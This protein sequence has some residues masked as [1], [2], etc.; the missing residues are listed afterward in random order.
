MIEYKS[1]WQSSWIRDRKCT[2]LLT[3]QETCHQNCVVFCTPKNVFCS[4]HWQRQLDKICHDL[5]FSLG[6][7]TLNKMGSN[8]F[9]QKSHSFMPLSF[10]EIFLQFWKK[11]KEQTGNCSTY[12]YWI[13]QV[14]HSNIHWP[15]FIWQ[16]FWRRKIQLAAFLK[17]SSWWKEV[18]NVNIVICNI[19][20]VL[21]LKTPL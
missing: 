10:H 13:D 11:T 4:V 16:I 6:Y 17:Q 9:W 3:C 5:F 8:Q 1:R 12:L 19:I 2:D 18:L 7:W 21:V 14:D 15:A 20:R